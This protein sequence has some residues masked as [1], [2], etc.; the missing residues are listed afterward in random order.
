MKRL[1]SILLVAAMVIT[2]A[3]AARIPAYAAEETTLVVGTSR[4]NGNFSPFFAGTAYDQ[5]IADLTMVDLLTKDRQ[6][7]GE[8]RRN[9]SVQR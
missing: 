7:E 6:G 5:D 2:F 1:L 3:G 8:D 9:T 4:L